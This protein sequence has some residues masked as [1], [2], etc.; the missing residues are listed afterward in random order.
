MAE[1]AANF[2]GSDILGGPAFDLAAH[3]GSYVF[4]AFMGLPWCGPCKMELPH[5]VAVANEYAAG[6]PTPAVDF[7]IVNS[8]QSFQNSAIATYAKEQGVTMPIIDDE[9]SAILLSYAGN[10]TVPQS[11][12][13][14]PTGAL[15]DSHKVGAGTAEELIGLLV[16]CG[17]PAPGSSAQ[18]PVIDW[19]S[20]PYPVL[21]FPP[22]GPP[23][24]FPTPVRIPPPGPKPLSLMSRA[25]VRAL[26][27]HDAASGL[28]HHEASTAIRSAALKAAA[29]SLRRMESLATLKAELGPLPPYA[30]AVEAGRDR[31]KRADS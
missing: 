13:V 21:S 27:I 26:A 22:Y 15:C 5:L 8:R 24:D 4:V 29:A 25:V 23:K 20:Q 1:Q 6:P 28:A 10:H 30:D 14:K 31:K 12:I 16:E 2:S 9:G 19:G 7:V 3:K 18:I 11:F 17:A